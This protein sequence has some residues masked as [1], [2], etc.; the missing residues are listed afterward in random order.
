[1]V[2][3]LR[4]VDLERGILPVHVRPLEV[5]EF[6]GEPLA[7]KPRQGEGLFKRHFGVTPAKLRKH[8]QGVVVQTTLPAT[9]EAPSLGSAERMVAC[10]AVIAT[11]AARQTRLSSAEPGRALETLGEPRAVTIDDDATFNGGRW[12]E[13]TWK[14]PRPA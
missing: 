10:C 2:F 4:L 14:D 6:A 9:V 8:E 1:M 7:A 12:L 11:A 3:D 13:A 5:Y